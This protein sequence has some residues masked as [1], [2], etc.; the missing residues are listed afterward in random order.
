MSKLHEWEE[1]WRNDL[2][3]WIPGET[4][5][6]RN[7]DIFEDFRDKPWM[8]LFMYSLTG[9]EFSPKQIQLLEALWVLATSY[10]EPKLWNNRIGSIAGSARC[11]M[12]MGIAAGTS[13]SEAI[14]YGTRPF[15][16]SFHF[17]ESSYEDSRNGIDLTTLVKQRL[18]APK[19]SA[20]GKGRDRALATLP[21]F[22]RPITKQDERIEPLLSVAR[23]LELAGPYTDHL[24]KIE[25]TVI[26][27]GSPLRPNAAIFMA[28][29][30]LD[31][32]IDHL[33]AGHYIALTFTSGIAACLIDALQ[34]PEGC[35][36]PLRCSRIQYEGPDERDW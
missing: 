32:E 33:T 14:V 2:G 26:A 35:F 21:G 10:P 29:L 6:V 7:K 3:A 24:L 25:E 28:S 16:R 31:Q 5:K 15:I 4:V 23:S 8:D 9:R 11:S 20:S 13:T 18:E 27:L 36:L 30:M 22:G 17:L 19:Q 12:S 1:N 34:K